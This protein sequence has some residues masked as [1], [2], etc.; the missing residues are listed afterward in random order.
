[1]GFWE[2]APPVRPLRSA[3]ERGASRK[4]AR[5][6]V[7]GSTR[8]CSTAVR[9]QRCRG[10][11]RTERRDSRTPAQI[12]HQPSCQ[13]STYNPGFPATRDPTSQISDVGY[14][15]SNQAHHTGAI[16][17]LVGEIDTRKCR[18]GQL[19][20]CLGEFPFDMAFCNCREG[21]SVGY[22]HINAL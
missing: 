19:V 3:P 10:S 17:A 8:A 7:G 22:S 14:R 13:P 18:N 6:K 15:R 9:R 4:L 2:L 16:G 1:M 21:Y 20:I 12:E 11:R 5:L